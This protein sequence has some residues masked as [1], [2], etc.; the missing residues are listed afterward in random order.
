MGGDLGAQKQLATHYQSSGKSV[1]DMRRV[2]RWYQ[3]GIATSEWELPS[4]YFYLG[5]LYH[6]GTCV[7]KDSAAALSW[8]QRA[9]NQ[10][11]PQPLTEADWEQ[12]R[13]QFKRTY[14]AARRRAA[15]PNVVRG[16]LKIDDV[17]HTLEL[18]A[19]DYRSGRL[20]Q[21]SNTII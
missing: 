9:A 17:S 14:P 10:Q 5:L 12:V 4:E 21:Y 8:F 15:N 16:R 6:S 2:A 3:Q 20:S 18:V 13:A 11:H 19:Q 1:S 7:A